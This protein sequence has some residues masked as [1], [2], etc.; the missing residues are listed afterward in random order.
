MKFPPLKFF[1]VVVV[2]VVYPRVGENNKIGRRK[3]RKGKR[4]GGR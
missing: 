4:G 3:G 1:V 2:V